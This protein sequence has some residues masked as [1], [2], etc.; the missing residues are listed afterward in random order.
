MRELLARVASDLVSLQAP[1]AVVGGHAVSART[2]PRFT[3][4]LDL[5]VAVAD[6]R[7][8]EALVSALVARGYRIAAL[9]EQEA[10]GRLATVRLEH[11]SAPGVVV[12]LLFATAGVEPEVVAG[13]SSLQVIDKLVLPVA[14]VGH[15]L[16]LKTLSMDDRKRPQ[17]RVDIGALLGVATAEDLRT[18]ERAM[19]LITERGCNRGRDLVALFMGLRADSARP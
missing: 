16:A 10:T 1:H 15:L 9:I 4:D 14:S 5:A 18:A 6:D 11:A 19:R 3:R 12:D 7:R 13:A 2:E 8:A 17:D